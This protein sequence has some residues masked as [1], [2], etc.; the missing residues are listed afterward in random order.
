MRCPQCLSANHVVKTGI[1]NTKKGPIQKYMCR[2]CKKSFSDSPQPYTQ[3]P[4]KVI[5]HSLEL[6][7]LGYPV[8]MVRTEIGKRYPCSPPTRTIY[9]WI[10]RFGDKLDFSELR[11]KYDIHPDEVIKEKVFNH[12]QVFPFRYHSLK[13]NIFNRTYPGMKRYI[14]WVERSL[15]DRMFLNGPRASTFRRAKEIPVKE[16]EDK[17]TELCRLSLLRMSN[18]NSAHDSIE[19]FILIN[20]SITVCTE[21]PVFLNP[22]ESKDLGIRVPLTGHIDIIQ[23]KDNKIRILDYKPNLNRPENFAS[24]LDLYRRCFSRRT[25]IPEKEISIGVFNEHGYMEYGC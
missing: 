18:R 6:Y 3:Y 14:N 24:Q 19:S 1:R 23:M 7:N 25:S 9:S 4:M 20:D 2:S 11:K 21:L 15:P 5:L 17:I 16:K 10:R 8:S 12:Q 13:L 22:S